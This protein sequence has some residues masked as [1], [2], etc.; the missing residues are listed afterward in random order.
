MVCFVCTES[1]SIYIF[2]IRGRVTNRPTT[3]NRFNIMSDLGLK[4]QINVLLSIANVSSSNRVERGSRGSC[5]L[6][7]VGGDDVIIM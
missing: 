7:V 1:T 2:E 5:G 6:R 3:T 4:C